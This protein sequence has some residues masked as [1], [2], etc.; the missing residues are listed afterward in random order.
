MRFNWSAILG[1][2]VGGAVAAVVTG[3]VVRNFLPEA[4]SDHTLAETGIAAL[5]AAL[6]GV[7]G[8]VAGWLVHRRRSRGLGGIAAFVTVIGT[9]W[10]TWRWFSDGWGAAS[11]WWTLVE[12]VLILG[13]GLLVLATAS[14]TAAALLQ[15]RSRV[16][17]ET[18]RPL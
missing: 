14:G 3:F 11:T 8:V 2:L 15:H 16:D 5:V 13:L 6:A 1:G 17:P 7:L 18:G 9:G 4:G 12:G 10:G